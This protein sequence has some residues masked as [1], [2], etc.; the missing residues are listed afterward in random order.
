[1]EKKNSAG[2]KHNHQAASN[3]Q[4]QYID[5]GKRGSVATKEAPSPWICTLMWIIAT[6][7]FYDTRRYID[8][9]SQ[10]LLGE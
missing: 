4:I 7:N 5:A 10:C 8:P 1:M 6:G 9:R 3:R 2:F